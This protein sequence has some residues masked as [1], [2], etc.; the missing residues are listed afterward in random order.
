LVPFADSPALADALIDLLRNE[1]KRHVMRKNAYKLGRDMVWKNVAHKYWECF[2]NS[3]ISRGAMS[4]NLF[5][6]KTLDKQGLNLPRFKFDHLLRIVDSTGVFQHAVYTVPN[7]TEGYCT[8]DNA[9]C[10][11]LTV[12]LEELGNKYE[13][14]KSIGSICAA[15]LNYAL[16]HSTGRFRNFMGFNREWLE[17]QGSDDSHG[18]ALWA[19]GTCIGRSKNRGLRNLAGQLWEIALPSA[20]DITSPRACAFILVG[21]HEYLRHLS[22]D[23]YA[24]QLRLKLTKRLLK[25]YL[26]C[27][28][29]DWPWFEDVVSYSNAKLPH[30]LILSG[31]WTGDSEVLQIGLKALGWLCSI[32]TSKGGYFRPIG[33]N[34][35]YRR[36]T[37]QASFDQQP[38]E[39]PS[40]ISACI[41]A[42]HA[43]G[44]KVWMK[45]ACIAFDWF[46]GRND[47]GI[48]LYDPESGGCCDGL[49]VDRINENQGAESTLA[50]LLSLAE[51]Q[52]MQ[53]NILAFKEPS[54]MLEK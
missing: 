4:R 32:Q 47:L 50:F 10:L 23:R 44:D 14:M 40:M 27:A 42:F 33:S 36:N 28:S 35:F 31:R 13:S 46:L 24:N 52:L 9:R 21:I 49:H 17:R 5:T 22:G 39:A 51:M 20:A 3:R 48:P 2:E 30:A 34:G 41:E 19:L 37:L 6:V 7:F 16:D 38:V 54:V 8:D 29:D 18:R 26:E 15:F 45:N 53:N 12:L 43:T 1:V 11:I 25:L